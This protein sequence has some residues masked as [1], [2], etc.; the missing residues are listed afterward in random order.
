MT[1]TIY[2]TNRE[3]CD[4]LYRRGFVN[5]VEMTRHF[6]RPSEMSRAIGGTFGSVVGRWI[7]GQNNPSYESE[8]KAKAWVDAN[9]KGNDVERQP[10]QDAQQSAQRPQSGKVLLVA[11]PDGQH[12][13]VVKILAMV[14]CEVVE[15]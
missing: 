7:R 11:C 5:V 9:L 8:A 1:K 3:E 2:D 4:K 10:K 15:I 13:K 12:E 6:H 14:G